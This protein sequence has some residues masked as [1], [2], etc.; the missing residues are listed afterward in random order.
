MDAGR[1]IASRMDSGRRSLPWKKTFK[2]LAAGKM[3][4][5]RRDSG[6][7]QDALRWALRESQGLWPDTLW[8]LC[9][10]S[11]QKPTQFS[12]WLSQVSSNP[13]AWNVS[14]DLLKAALGGRAR[15]ATRVVK[16][17]WVKAVFHQFLN[18]SQHPDALLALAYSVLHVIVTEQAKLHCKGQVCQ[19]LCILDSW[20]WN[21]SMPTTQRRSRKRIDVYLFSGQLGTEREMGDLNCQKVKLMRC[22]VQR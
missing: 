10:A 1:R 3:L 18:K 5:V 21:L 12:A 9:A 19:F 4:E 20:V 15:E 13:P 6:N 8:Y 17:S 7:Q 22:H 14:W 11:E 2:I 16:S